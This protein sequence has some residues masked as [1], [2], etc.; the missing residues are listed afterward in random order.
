MEAL[1]VSEGDNGGV[2]VVVVDAV[3]RQPLLS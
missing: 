3:G 2:A 1:V